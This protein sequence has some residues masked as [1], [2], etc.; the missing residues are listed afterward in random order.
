MQVG[1]FALA[2]RKSWRA[3][4]VLTHNK[5]TMS[6][7]RQPDHDDPRRFRRRLAALAIIAALGL[8]ALTARLVWLLVLR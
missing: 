7:I 5:E 6:D 4:P 1:V 2:D 3:G 8:A